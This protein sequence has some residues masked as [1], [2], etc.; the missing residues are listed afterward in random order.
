MESIYTAVYEK[1]TT[2]QWIRRTRAFHCG[3]AAP[4]VN[5]ARG[6]GRILAMLKIQPEIATKDLAY[7]LGIRQQSLNEQLKKLEKGGYVE[8]KPS[9]EDRRV[10][11]VHLTEKGKAVEQVEPESRYRKMFD[12]LTKEEV[13]QLGEY[14]DRIIASFDKQDDW[15]EGDEDRFEWMGR[16]RERMG[17]E[18]FNRLMEMRERRFGTHGGFSARGPHKRHGTHG[19]HSMNSARDRCGRQGMHADRGMYDMSS[20]CSM[21]GV[22]GKKNS[23][24]SG[25]RPDHLPGAE[26]FSPDYDGPVPDRSEPFPWMEEKEGNSKEE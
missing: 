4:F 16:A 21:G 7:L 1:L 11:I 8:R 10:M 5:T 20:G 22:R 18:S 2:L 9:E 12:C 26:R 13:E 3:G 24:R 23:C 15:K 6:Q 17:E 19:A 14:L 25:G